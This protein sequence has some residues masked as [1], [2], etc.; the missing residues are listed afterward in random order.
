MTHNDIT[1]NAMITKPAN[2]AYRNGYDAIWG[3]KKEEIPE[4]EVTSEYE[5]KT[6]D[7]TK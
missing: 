6:E 2:D 5:T 3:K 1:G 7:K 4:P